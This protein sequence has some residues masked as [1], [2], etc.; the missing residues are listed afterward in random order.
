[1]SKTSNES[2]SKTL[3]NSIS[4][5]FS[6]NTSE[7]KPIENSSTLAPNT[8]INSS[9]VF[10]EKPNTSNQQSEFGSLV[11][12][13]REQ[14]KNDLNNDKLTQTG[15][16]QID[17]F[18]KNLNL[19]FIKNKNLSNNTSNKQTP[20]PAL[21]E[22]VSALHE[23]SFFEA[24]EFKRSTNNMSKSSFG[25]TVFSSTQH[26]YSNN[27]STPSSELSKN[28]KSSASIETVKT[29]NKRIRINLMELARNE[30]QHQYNKLYKKIKN[31]R[32]QFATNKLKN[33]N[34]KY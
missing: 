31:T 10:I 32:E 2:R 23:K 28:S 6:A 9:A 1:M 11:Y 5:L 7:T 18:E 30:S 20:T 25:D 26:N 21:A 19:D 34:L 17:L 4:Q 15:Q 14:S 8:G 24:S 16:Q 29:T 12:I 22:G 27:Y 13:N 3:V 33:I